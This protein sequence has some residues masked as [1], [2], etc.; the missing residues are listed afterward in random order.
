MR[1]PDFLVARVRETLPVAAAAKC[2]AKAKSC[3][4]CSDSTAQFDTESVVFADGTDSARASDS[5]R[6]VRLEDA[7]RCHGI[8]LLWSLLSG[9]VIDIEPGVILTINA[10]LLYSLS[11]DNDQ[12]EARGHHP[13]PP[14][15]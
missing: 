6:V 7:A 15:P 1:P 3:C 11:L 5:L 4:C 9:V 10:P 8:D 13:D 14:V 12:A 2:P